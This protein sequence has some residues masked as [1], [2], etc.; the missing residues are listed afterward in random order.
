MRQDMIAAYKRGWGLI[1]L[2]AD[3]KL[4][5][6]PKG[7]P[8][9]GRKATREEYA[10]FDFGN[11]GIVCGAVSGITVLDLDLPEGL[12]NLNEREISML[13]T[14]TPYAE[15]PNGRH[16]FFKYNPAV[17]T[18]VAVLGKGVDIRNDGSYIVGPGSSV[19]GLTY[20]W[21][22]TPEEVEYEETP[23]W[24]VKGKDNRITSEPITF[25]ERIQNGERNNRLAS[26]AG[27]LFYKGFPRPVVESVVQSINREWCVSPLPEDEV[28]RTVESVRRYHGR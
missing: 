6:L 2:R 5:N 8:F 11:Y 26:L 19:E 4:P 17:K 24:M 22:A 13:D 27:T 10:Q 23:A 25:E 18:G 7:H 1:P 9:L 16:Y 28:S 21:K 12:D 15:T 14:M 3:S 20:Q